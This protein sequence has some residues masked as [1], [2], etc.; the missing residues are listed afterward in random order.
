MSTAGKKNAI[1][2]LHFPQFFFD[3]DTLNLAYLKYYQDVVAFCHTFGFKQEILL[4]R[5][6]SSQ[7]AKRH[8]KPLKQLDRLRIAV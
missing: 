6:I 2:G 3:L 7:E 1:A 5:I 4:I 8:D